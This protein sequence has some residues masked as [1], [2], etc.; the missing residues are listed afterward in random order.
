[1][2]NNNIINYDYMI[3]VLVIGDSGVGKSS[4]VVR[5]TDDIYINSY[6]STIGVDFKVNK[7]EINNKIIKM[8]LWDTAGQERFRTITYSYYRGSHAVILVFD[9]TN[10]DSFLNLNSWL[11]EINKYC[12]C[13]NIYITLI[14]NKTDLNDDRA[15]S[16]DEANKFAN[17]N[18]MKYYEISTLNSEYSN[19]NNIFYNIGLH[20]INNNCIN[21][22]Q[23][24]T[25][26][27]IKNSNKNKNK[28]N[29]CDI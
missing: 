2:S 24:N 5:Y 12:N 22:I 28:N 8:Q 20:L 6:I 27:N 26:I 7:F 18:N 13:D 21:S 25:N 3:K 16:F 19:I 29:C 17:D 10:R 14:G 23:N 9:I 1:M 4:F 15:V 11:N